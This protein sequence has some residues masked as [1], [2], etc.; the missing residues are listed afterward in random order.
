[1]GWNG[2]DAP[3]PGLRDKVEIFLSRS[4]DYWEPERYVKEGS[5]FPLQT[6]STAVCSIRQCLDLS[7]CLNRCHHSICICKVEIDRNAFFGQFVCVCAC[8]IDNELR[9][10]LGISESV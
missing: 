6:G 10:L 5:G 9:Y 1:V 8:S 3:F 4:P 7:L 2:E